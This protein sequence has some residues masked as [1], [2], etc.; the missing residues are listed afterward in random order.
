MYLSPLSQMPVAAEPTDPI[1]AM[2][3]VFRDSGCPMRT[4]L[5]GGC[6]DVVLSLTPSDEVVRIH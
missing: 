5:V 6:V 1:V 2:S 4:K 3:D